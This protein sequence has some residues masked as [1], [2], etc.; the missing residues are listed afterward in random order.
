MVRLLA[1]YVI[2]GKG[3]TFVTGVMNKV[4]K[5]LCKELFDTLLGELQSCATKLFHSQW[6]CGRICSRCQGVYHRNIVYRVSVVD[7][8]NDFLVDMFWETMVMTGKLLGER[9][10]SQSLAP[11]GIS[12]L[13]RYDTIDAVV[14]WES[15]RWFAILRV[16]WQVS[17]RWVACA[18]TS[19]VRGWLQHSCIVDGVGQVH[20]EDVGCLRLWPREQRDFWEWI[21][22][23]KHGRTSRWSARML[24]ELQKLHLWA[25]KDSLWEIQSSTL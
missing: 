20:R 17:S 3:R 10:G 14:K 24:R 4:V 18:D 23:L 6:H 7:A 15:A 11:Y 5:H 21:C 8:V 9:G 13:A 19:M 12:S 22:V 2:E 25:S 16:P 1:K